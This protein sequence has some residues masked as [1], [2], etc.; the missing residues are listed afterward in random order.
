MRLHGNDQ[1]VNAV[2]EIIAVYTENHTIQINTL[3]RQNS[4]LLVLKHV[5]Q[6]VT[7]KL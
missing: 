7:S 5:V 3:C 2:R 6:I 4:E 1:L